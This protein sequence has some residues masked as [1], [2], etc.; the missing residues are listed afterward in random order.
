M[1]ISQSEPLWFGKKD[2]EKR[3]NFNYGNSSWHKRLVESLASKG[4]GSASGTDSENAEKRPWTNGESPDTTSIPRGRKPLESP[5]DPHLG[6]LTPSPT[7]TMTTTI[8]SDKPQRRKLQKRN[9]SSR[10]SSLHSNMGHQEAP[11]VFGLYHTDTDDS[12]PPPVVP[13]Q[14]SRPQSHQWIRSTSQDSI[15]SVRPEWWTESLTPVPVSARSRSN[16]QVGSVSIME[17][18][19][20]QAYGRRASS[21]VSQRSRS[22]SVSNNALNRFFN[23]DLLTD[24]DQAQSHRRSAS[25]HVQ[26][27][28]LH[29]LPSSFSYNDPHHSRRSDADIFIDF[30]NNRDNVDDAY[31]GILD[32][33]E[34]ERGRSGIVR[35]LSQR[36]TYL[37]DGVYEVMEGRVRQV[38]AGRA[39]GVGGSGSERRA[40]ARG[41]G[42]AR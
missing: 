21:R 6:P 7:V 24:E 4:S 40:S 15:H 27:P 14:R 28:P 20:D 11:P 22:A 1:K 10:A 31:P 13:L 25:L 37:P 33:E 38:S 19:P 16:S 3:L 5:V 9:S 23:S 35:S 32:P 42:R 39:P 41:A 12:A 26:P 34:S 18:H 8:T 30:S 29:Q 36:E 2:P 17:H